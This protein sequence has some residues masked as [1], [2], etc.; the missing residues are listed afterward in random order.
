MKYHIWTEG[1]QMNTAD[2][3]FLASE[4]EKLGLRATPRPEAADV[5]VLNT[6]VVRQSAEDRAIG[7]L[8]SLRPL[9]DK[10]PDVVLGLMGCFVGVRDYKPLQARFPFVDVFL[11]PSD[12]SR[13]VE[14]L[15]ARPGHASI[16]EDAF[17][18]QS[19]TETRY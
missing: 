18:D 11:P 16:P 17:V 12:P 4:L 5:I 10:N 7:R 8:Y 9:K 19:E 1:C 2:S 3:Q 15:R 6:C 13:L 14:L